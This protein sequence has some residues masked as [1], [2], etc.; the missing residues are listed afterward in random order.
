MKKKPREKEKRENL[1][2]TMKSSNGY[3][4]QG[5]QGHIYYIVSFKI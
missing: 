2:K 5:C 1:K 3:S 4:P